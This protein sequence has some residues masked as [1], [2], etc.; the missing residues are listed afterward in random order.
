MVAR[1]ATPGKPRRL[2]AINAW[3]AYILSMTENYL[4]VARSALQ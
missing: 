4:E 1:F 2:V 3:R